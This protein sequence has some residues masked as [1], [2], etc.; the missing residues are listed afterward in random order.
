MAFVGFLAYLHLRVVQVAYV[1]SESMAPTLTRGDRLLVSLG[2]TRHHPPRRG[3]VIVFRSARDGG[4]EVKRVIGIGGDEIVT[5]WGQ[6]YRNGQRLQES[7]I[8]HRMV[9]ERPG[10]WT[11]PQGS[12]F[13]M[14]DNRN[15]SEDSRDW[16]PLQDRQILGRVVYRI[17]PLSR[18]GEIKVGTG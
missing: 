16:G 12:I 14:G 9:M 10:R 3:D 15:H 5:I 13:V 17:L 18:A 7:Y 2:A 6:V 8:K 11:V 1:P 4:Y